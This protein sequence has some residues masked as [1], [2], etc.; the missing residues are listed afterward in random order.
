MTSNAEHVSIWWRHHAIWQYRS[1]D[2]F[3]P[4]LVETGVALLE[5]T[6]LGTV[7]KV[8]F[9]GREGVG[10]GGRGGVVGWGGGGGVEWLSGG[11]GGGAVLL[12]IVL[13]SLL[14]VEW[15]LIQVTGRF[16]AYFTKKVSPNLVKLSVDYFG[17][18][19]KFR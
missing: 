7:W 1:D 3:I 16:L 13:R 4:G 9:N 12:N 19:C 10:G 8:E 2:D 17:G 15:L 6:D 18:L 5:D 11:G 14:S